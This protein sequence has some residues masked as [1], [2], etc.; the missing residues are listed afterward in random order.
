MSVDDWHHTGAVRVEERLCAVGQ[1]TAGDTV[2]VNRS[3]PSMDTCGD[4]LIEWLTIENQVSRRFVALR[5]RR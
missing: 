4:M 1:L 5:K 2:A 3:G